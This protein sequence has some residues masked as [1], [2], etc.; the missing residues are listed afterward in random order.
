VSEPVTRFRPPL[1]PERLP[2][3]PIEAFS[4]WLAQAETE[5]EMNYPNALTLSTVTPEGVPDGRIVLLKGVDQRG[6]HFFSNY[7]SEKGRALADRPRAALTFYWDGM[8]RQVR[9]RGRVERLSPEESDEY[10]RSRPRGSQ[11]GAWA[12]RQSRSVESR[13]ALMARYRAL[14]EEY[15]GKEVPRPEHWGGYVL[16]PDE[17]ELWQEAPFRM[18]DRLLYRRG[19]AGWTLTRLSP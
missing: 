11:L 15:E 10:F 7:E 3:D 4:D 17:V 6:F 18:H 2:D 1:A 12:S 16:R 8:G 14:E 19:D 9:V 13:E 5:S